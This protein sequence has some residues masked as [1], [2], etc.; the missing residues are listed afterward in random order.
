M[1]GEFKFVDA[2]QVDS[3]DEF[4]YKLVSAAELL[5][6]F[7]DVQFKKGIE[8]ASKLAVELGWSSFRDAIA[9][10]R[11]NTE[12]VVSVRT[13]THMRVLEAVG[14]KE[15]PNSP[16]APEPSGTWQEEFLSLYPR[17]RT[18]AL[19]ACIKTRLGLGQNEK[20][21]QTMISQK[22]R[23]S[24]LYAYYDKLWRIHERLKTDPLFCD[25]HAHVDAL[26][27][28]TLLK[29]NMRLLGKKKA[30]TVRRAAN[31]STTPGGQRY[32]TAIPAEIWN[33]IKDIPGVSELPY[34]PLS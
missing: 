5:E 3:I 23:H 27:L 30:T 32:N 11:E 6:E 8:V 22:N 13:E 16:N 28:Y 7:I 26:D 33:Q 15:S 9:S 12:A 31:R 20:S 18:N 2:V 10:L 34:Q 21:V 14:R 17:L 1:E 4:D 25:G 29:G 19:A 24:T